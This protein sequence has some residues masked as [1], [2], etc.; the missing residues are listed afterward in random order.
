M[1]TRAIQDQIRK[2]RLGHG[3]KVTENF[4]HTFTQDERDA[5]EKL[6]GLFRNWM[7]CD[8]QRE[9]DCFPESLPNIKKGLLAT[10]SKP[11]RISRIACGGWIWTND[12]RVMSRSC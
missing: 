9:T 12:P 10:P 5:A 3:A 4:A 7:A 2:Q 6:G 1:D 8:R 11:L